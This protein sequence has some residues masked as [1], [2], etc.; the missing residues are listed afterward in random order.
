MSLVAHDA[1]AEPAVAAEKGARAHW[2]RYG[3]PVLGLLLP[4]GLALAGS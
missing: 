2:S 3:R 1:T 4:V